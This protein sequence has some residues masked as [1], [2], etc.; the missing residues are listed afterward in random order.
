M[1]RDQDLYKIIFGPHEQ[2]SKLGVH[3]SILV[4]NEIFLTKTY[5]LQE[6]IRFLSL[7]FGK[8]SSTKFALNKFT[9][10]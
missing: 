5:L 9:L 6:I 7:T 2:N 1:W 10:M 3:D 8:V 4:V